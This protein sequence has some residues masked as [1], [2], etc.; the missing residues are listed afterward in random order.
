[1]KILVGIHP[2]GAAGEF[3]KCQLANPD[4][5]LIMF[6]DDIGHVLESEEYKKVPGAS[7]RVFCLAGCS[8]SFGAYKESLLRVLLK[9]WQK[10]KPGEKVEAYFFGGSR[11]VCFQNISRPT[12][13]ALKRF[14]KKSLTTKD[15]DQFI[16]GPVSTA[17][18]E[19]SY[20]AQRLRRQIH[21]MKQN[22][23]LSRPAPTVVAHA[24]KH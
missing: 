1:M 11:S 18:P 5:H 9:L 3:I 10:R 7:E 15:L 6:P 8:A 12:K 21:L 16:Y 22:A 4:T 20:S 19:R 2:T 17:L 24:R 13:L 14:F 23:R